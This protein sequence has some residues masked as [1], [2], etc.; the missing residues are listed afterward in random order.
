L[1]I[2]EA[3]YLIIFDDISSYIQET[4]VQ[5]RSVFMG[6]KVLLNLNT[7]ILTQQ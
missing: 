7:T 1:R 6:Q 4:A 2:K 3:K 5:L